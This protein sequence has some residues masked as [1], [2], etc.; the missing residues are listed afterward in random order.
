LR[1]HDVR[2][3]LN[4]RSS[5]FERDL[6]PHDIP[7]RDI[8]DSERLPLTVTSGKLDPEDVAPRDLHWRP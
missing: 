1:E 3:I 5:L 2:Q 8:G 6:Q 4:S 7:A